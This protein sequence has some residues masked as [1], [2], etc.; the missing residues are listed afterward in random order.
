MNTKWKTLGK[1]WDGHETETR[2]LLILALPLRDFE[3]VLGVREPRPQL[4]DTLE[5]P[6]FYIR[7]INE[8]KGRKEPVET[9]Q[10]EKS[11]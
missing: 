2:R 9:H 10:L 1:L 8:G 7:G 6:S 3:L 11:E 4:L 5:P